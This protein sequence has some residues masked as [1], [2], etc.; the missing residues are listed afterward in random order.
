MRKFGVIGWKN[1]GKTHL[2]V[3]LVSELTSRGFT[4]ST[5]KHAHHSLEFST[6]DAEGQ[7]Q[8]PARAHEAIFSSP[9][10]WSL[11]K[12]MPAGVEEER[13]SELAARLQP[14]DLVLVEGYKLEDLPKLEAHRASNKRDLIARK[15]DRVVAMASDSA[16]EGV[17][18][19]VFDLDDTSAIADFVL[20]Y[21]GLA[22]QADKA[23]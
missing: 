11:M 6:S 19:P 1:S 18:V 4:I 14:V 12:E 17:N 13:L 22:K 16:V 5:I 23:G 15:D 10:R 9:T 3:R 7:E 21:V 20:E 2:V 8:R